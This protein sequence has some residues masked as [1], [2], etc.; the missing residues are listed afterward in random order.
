MKFEPVKTKKIYIEIVNQINKMIENGELKPGDKLPGELHLAKTFNTSRSSLREALSALEILGVIDRRRG[1]G[2][3]IKDNIDSSKFT[4][5]LEELNNEIGAFEILEA[6]KAIEPSI[7]RLAAEKRIPEHIRKLEELVSEMPKALEAGWWRKVNTEFHLTIARAAD[8]PV[9]Y[10]TMRYIAETMR[11]F[12][13][14]KHIEDVTTL[15]SDEA[16]TTEFKYYQ[17]HVRLVE[18]IKNGK[19]DIAEMIMMDHIEVTKQD[20]I[21]KGKID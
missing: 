6:R 4:H 7:V 18:A 15:D 21:D 11:N 2:H 20:F 1:D 5:A 8:N 16:K 19:K 12:V 14:W 13:L 3:Y 9:L 10:E 17:D